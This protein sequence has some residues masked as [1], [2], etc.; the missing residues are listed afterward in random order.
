MPS[1]Q[2]TCIHEEQSF[3]D[4]GRIIDTGISVVNLKPYEG[5]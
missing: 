1:Y 2:Y 3:T 5:E 4:M